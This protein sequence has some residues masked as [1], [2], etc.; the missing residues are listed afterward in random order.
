[1]A[2]HGFGGVFHRSWQKVSYSGTHTIVDSKAIN[3]KKLS[4]LRFQ[5]SPDTSSKRRQVLDGLGV[6]HRPERVA[7]DGQQT[8]N[9][10]NCYFIFNFNLKLFGL[11]LNFNFKYFFNL[12]FKPK[13]VFINLTM[14]YLILNFNLNVLFN[15]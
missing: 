3:Q 9:N 1:M 8:E 14:F 5:I 6:A 2:K 10:S 11:I 7:V 15:L 12:Q 4:I 13:T